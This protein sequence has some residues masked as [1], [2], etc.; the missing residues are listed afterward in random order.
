[1]E[2]SI[3]GKIP[4]IL[5][6]DNFLKLRKQS[7]GI[8]KNPLTILSNQQYLELDG[9]LEMVPPMSTT[10]ENFSLILEKIVL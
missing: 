2:E 6:S 9:L 5:P 8:L 7:L 1:M 4:T 10:A 3:V